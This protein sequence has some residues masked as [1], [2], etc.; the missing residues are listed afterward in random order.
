MSF[1]FFAVRAVSPSSG[2]TRGGTVVNVSGVAFG[3]LGN[4]RC[5]FGPDAQPVNKVRADKSSAHHGTACSIHALEAL[6]HSLSS[7]ALVCA[8]PPRDEWHPH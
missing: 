2:P 7:L 8:V 1:P 6:K 3:A 4:Y 5:S